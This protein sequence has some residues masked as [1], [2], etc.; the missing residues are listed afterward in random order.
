MQEGDEMK[1]WRKKQTRKHKQNVFNTV[2][3]LKT[4]KHAILAD[5]VLF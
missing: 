3:T 4:H 2:N 5:T 1:E